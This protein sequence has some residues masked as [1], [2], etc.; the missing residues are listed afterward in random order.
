MHEKGFKWQKSPYYFV[1]TRVDTP[2]RV[3]NEVNV[4][5]VYELVRI[6]FISCKFYDEIKNKPE[7]NHDSKIVHYDLYKKNV[8][9]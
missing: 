2:P 3:P 7:K 8:Q 4:K 9:A 1:F 5:I 6:P